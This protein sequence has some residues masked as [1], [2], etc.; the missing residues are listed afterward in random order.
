MINFQVESVTA[1]LEEVKPLLEEH[2]REI[3][4]YQDQFPLNPNY[5]KY[6]ALDSMGMVHV[7]T[8]RVGVMGH[9]SSSKG[10]LIGYY[11][12]FVMPHLHYQDCI[13]AI[14]DI[15]FLKKEHRHSRAGY[16][17]IRFAE[18]ELKKIGVHRMIMH[19]KLDHDISPLLKRMGFT[20][21]EW[22]FEKLLN[23]RIV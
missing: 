19:I 3:A 11:I 2:W 4:L 6:K 9:G 18:Q 16:G 10:E 1:I 22:N 17:L 5:E 12:S 7:V 14:N 23:R 21:T 20:A 13:I 8:A 15:L